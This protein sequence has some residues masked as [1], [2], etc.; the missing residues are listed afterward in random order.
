MVKVGQNLAAVYNVTADNQSSLQCVAVSICVV[1]DHIGVAQWKSVGLWLAAFHW[2][3]LDLQLVEVNSA[4]R[5]FGVDK[6]V[7]SCNQM[8]ATTNHGAAVWRMFT[9][10]KAGMATLQGK[11]CG[12]YLSTSVVMFTKRRYTNVRPLP[13]YL[14][15]RL[16]TYTGQCGWAS[17]LCNILSIASFY[18]RGEGL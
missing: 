5:P 11:R 1:S 15:E 4:F 9:R 10:W 17:V 14:L 16:V 13:F 6:W 12:P 8:V 2:P 3:A 18:H 7:V